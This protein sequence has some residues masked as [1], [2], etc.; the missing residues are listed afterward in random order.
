MWGPAGGCSDRLTHDALSTTSVDD[1][2][3][4]RGEIPRTGWGSWILALWNRRRFFSGDLR[5]LWSS[6]FLPIRRSEDYRI[7]TRKALPAGFINNSFHF[8][9]PWSLIDANRHN[10]DLHFF[11]WLNLW[12]KS[13]NGPTWCKRMWWDQSWLLNKLTYDNKLDERVVVT[14]INSD[15]KCSSIEVWLQHSKIQWK[16]IVMARV[17]YCADIYIYGWKVVIT[18]KPDSKC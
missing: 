4:A 10:Q 3:L 17:R 18:T 9:S 16:P 14:T 11:I 6:L 7:L 15:S 1:R 12:Q 13:R 5:E 2:L 8:R